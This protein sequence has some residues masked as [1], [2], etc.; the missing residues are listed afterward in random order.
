MGVKKR[1]RSSQAH[2]RT[3]KAMPSSSV[4]LG[5]PDRWWDQVLPLVA[6]T[7]ESA[8]PFRA[9]PLCVV[10]PD[11]P[12][13]PRIR[14]IAGVI[15]VDQASE[16]TVNLVAA[17]NEMVM[18]MSGRAPEWEV[19]GVEPD[20]E[21]PRMEELGATAPPAVCAAVNFSLALPNE[22][23]LP[24]RPEDC[25]N[26]ATR[27][28]AHHTVPVVAAGNHHSPDA[29][30]E[31]VSPWG[32]P[33]WVLC[34]GATA[35]EA[36]TREWPHSARGTAARRDVGPDILAWGQD[37][38]DTS[39]FGT[40]FAAARVSNMLTISRAWL[41]QVH[42]NIEHRAGRPF[43]VPLVGVGI[44]DRGF[45]GDPCYDAP[46]RSGALPVL[47]AEHGGLD[48]IDDY[49][50]RLLDPQLARDVVQAAAIVS[51]SAD[52]LSAPAL[53]DDGLLAF[54]DGLTATHLRRIAAGDPAAAAVP[55]GPTVFPPNSAAVLKDVVQRT[56]PIWSF[57]IATGARF[58]RHERKGMREQRT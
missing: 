40:S 53:T 26:H 34:V 44:I 17:I 7:A 27:F 51:S 54:L 15:G 22:H 23:L 16:M 3:V 33:P 58:M 50:E 28:L 55:V 29:D 14:E 12:G 5:E 25:V 45:G 24:L 30:F 48:G 46:E 49:E 52:G 6:E 10:D 21:Y 42:A 32:E 36:G 8:S 18:L 47:A 39:E 20:E 11:D 37:P 1:S 38:F 31:T 56:M 57:N 4:I 43:G 2:S 19:G 9:I 13:L 35:D 41:S